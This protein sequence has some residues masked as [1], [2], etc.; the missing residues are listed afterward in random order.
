MVIAVVLLL[1]AAIVVDR[2]AAGR[3]AATLA[4]T[5]ES[6][7]GGNDVTA[8]IGGFPFLT[9]VA[10]GTFSQIDLSATSATYEGIELTDITADVSD[11]PFDLGTR[12]IG[13]V[14]ALTASATLPPASLET[15]L[16]QEL[17]ELDNVTL[18][19]RDGALIASTEVLGALP[20][21]INLV[22]RAA[23]GQIAVDIAEVSIAGFGVPISDLPEGLADQLT[24]IRIDIP[25]L[26]PGLTLSNI[27]IADDGVRVSIEGTD[28]DL[29]QS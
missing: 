12:E 4:A 7:Y 1:A 26:P 21:E 22:P 14:G 23:D 13:T 10:G 5:V 11:V 24:D 27:E 8:S 3:A 16:R 20:V 15:L 29:S 2:I 9:Q 17:A 28:V 25:S 18:T 6:Q 19:T